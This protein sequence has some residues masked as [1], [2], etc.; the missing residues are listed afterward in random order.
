MFI[1]YGRISS[2]TGV[3]II[4]I[5]IHVRLVYTVT[6]NAPNHSTLLDLFLLGKY[7]II[8]LSSASSLRLS[9][10]HGKLQLHKDEDLSS[11]RAVIFVSTQRENG[12]IRL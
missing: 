4:M 10:S 3:S 5:I 7:N 6:T 11:H 12:E 2:T 1:R 9:P 8:L